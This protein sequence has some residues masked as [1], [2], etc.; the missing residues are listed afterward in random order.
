M[1]MDACPA[2]VLG[3]DH[4]L[5]HSVVALSAADME[6]RVSQPA[7]GVVLIHLSLS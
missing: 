7:S 3:I 4:E 2:P 6:Q 1:E 5:D